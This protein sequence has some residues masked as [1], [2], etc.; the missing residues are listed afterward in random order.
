MCSSS[1]TRHDSSCSSY[2]R[3]HGGGE[4]VSDSS[5]AGRGRRTDVPHSLASNLCSRPAAS[6]AGNQSPNIFLQ[7]AFAYHNNTAK[8]SWHRIGD[9]LDLFHMQQVPTTTNA[10]SNFDADGIFSYIGSRHAID[11]AIR[12]LDRAHRDLGVLEVAAL[13]PV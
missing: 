1:T 2:E 5:L 10:N 3:Q 13:C 7:K 12:L 4:T 6:R 11:Q 8:P 9:E